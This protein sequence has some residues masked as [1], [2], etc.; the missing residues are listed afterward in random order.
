MT[1]TIDDPNEGKV[2]VSQ[3][4][5][6]TWTR[7]MVIFFRAMRGLG[8][9]IEFENGDEEIV[10]MVRDEALRSL[11]NDLKKTYQND[12]GE[13]DGYDDYDDYEEFPDLDD[14]DS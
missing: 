11:H 9:C 7:A 10:E 4:T 14:V 5:D 1:I 3:D 13:Y 12:N 8:Y 6:G 2:T